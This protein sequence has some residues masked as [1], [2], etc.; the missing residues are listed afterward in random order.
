MARRRVTQ[1]GAIEEL[2]RERGLD[3]AVNGSMGQEVLPPFALQSA[4]DIASFSPSLSLQS[5]NSPGAG[6]NLAPLGRDVPLTGR[7][8]SSCFTGV[9][10][11]LAWVYP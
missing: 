8:G 10:L 5:T 1:W 2:R 9:W 7:A 6:S 3:A 4:A 11:F